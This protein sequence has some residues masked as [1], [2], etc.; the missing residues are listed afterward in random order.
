MNKTWTL[1]MCGR[2]QYSLITTV[3][4]RQKSVKQ[5]NRGYS[6]SKVKPNNHGQTD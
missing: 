1:P 2:Y 6:A 4:V 3:I 5:K